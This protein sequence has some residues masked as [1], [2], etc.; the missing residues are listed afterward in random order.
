MGD[1]T[2]CVSFEDY[3]KKYYK[4]ALGYVQKHIS[5]SYDAE[6]IVSNAFFS[7]FKNFEKFDPQKASFATWLYVAINNRMK[8]F[9]RDKKDHGELIEEIE[10]GGKY[11]DEVV[12][13]MY[14]ENMREHLTRA[15]ESLSEKYKKIVVLKYFGNKDSNEIALEMGVSAGNVRVIL[16]RALDKIKEFFEENKIEFE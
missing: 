13:A 3:Y 16:M 12:E 4:Q 2:E 9:Y 7:C 6:D 11:Q 1:I 10:D 8:N 5:N 14:L 15:L